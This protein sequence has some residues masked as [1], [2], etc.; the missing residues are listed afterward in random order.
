MQRNCTHATV[1]SAP[2]TSPVMQLCPSAPQHVPGHETGPNRSPRRAAARGRLR[3]TR[4]TFPVP[5]LQRKKSHPRNETAPMQ[6]TH[7]NRSPARPRSCNSALRS[8]HVSGH[9]T[10]PNRS[11]R[12]AAARGRLR[13]TRETFP[14]PCLQRKKSHPRNE[15]AP[16][17]RTLLNRSPARP[18]ARN[19]PQLFPAQCCSTCAATIHEGN[20]PRAVLAKK[21][22]ASTQ[23]NCTHATNPPKPLPSTSP[24]T[25]PAPT[26]PRTVPQHVGGYDS[27]GK[28]SPCRACKGRNRIH[29]TKLHPCNEP[30]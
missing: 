15:T 13:F 21:E 8:Q 1:P 17:Q 26:V 9:E 2:S 12:R 22:I 19:R 14:V 7:L 11:P 27:R 5:C 4:E 6:R 16:M 30:A 20:I 29:A 25:N 24:G 28:H 10:G 3:F 23:R 18:R